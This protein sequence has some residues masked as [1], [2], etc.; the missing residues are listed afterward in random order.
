MKRLFVSLMVILM[1]CSFVFAGTVEAPKEA[2]ITYEDV[3]FTFQPTM[4]RYDAM[5][6]SG[7]AL[8]NRNDSFYSNPAVLADRGFALALPTVGV[9]FYNVY[10]LAKDKEVPDLAAAAAQGDSDAMINLGYKV[11]S[12]LGSGYN[13]LAKFDLGLGIKLGVI[14]LGSNLQVKIHALNNGVSLASQKLIPELNAAQTVAIG[15]K[16]IDTKYVSLSA[17][18]AGHLVYK[19]YYK[20]IGANDAVDIFNSSNGIEPLVWDVPVMGGYGIPLDLGATLSLFNGQFTIA[21]TANNL[22]GVYKMKSFSSAG[23]LVNSISEGTLTAPTDH[24]AKDSVDFE[25][26]T[27][28]S[29]NFGAALAPTGILLNPVISADLIDMYALVES[30]ISDF[31]NFR[32]SD[33]LLHLNA[34]AEISLLNVVSARVGVN[35]GFMSVGAGIWLP[36]A[37]VDASYGWQEFGMELGDKPVDSVTIKF[38]LGYDKH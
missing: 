4:A 15:L 16:L 1:A 35:R 32:W 13:T 28:W 25:V 5:G 29:L 21:A 26:K 31:N 30:M 9:T 20:D 24:E 19:A 17:G 33:L 37:Q 6:Q 27:P 3:D 36:F 8:M 10:D 38:N 18:V 12:N 22:N 11:L 34:G 23:D 2:A 7:L 14:G